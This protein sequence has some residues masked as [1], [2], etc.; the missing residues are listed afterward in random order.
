MTTRRQIVLALGASVL[1]VP[2]AAP[3]QVIAPRVRLIGVLTPVDN[4]TF[5]AFVDALRGLGY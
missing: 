1:A 2:F 5:V 4:P 3:G